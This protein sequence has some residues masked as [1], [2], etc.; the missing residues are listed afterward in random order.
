MGSA[1]LDLLR[2]KNFGHIDLMRYLHV[3]LFLITGRAFH[4]TSHVVFLIMLI[5]MAKGWTV[6]RYC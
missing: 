5:L 2:I 3:L 4:F 1:G 6:T